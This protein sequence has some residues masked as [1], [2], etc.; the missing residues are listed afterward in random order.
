MSDKEIIN[1][2]E[3]KIH[4]F[5]G[6]QV[7]L[8]RDIASL[9]KVETRVI[10]QAVKR[11]S[12]R[13]PDE[14]CFQLSEIEFH[15]WRSRIVMSNGDK[16]GLRR[17]PYAFTEQGVAML[18]AVLKSDTAVKVSVDILNTIRELI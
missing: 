17:P 5:R 14:F 3:N 12:E 10:N 8:D 6:M 7:M 18:S 9:Y 1:S 4:T 15:D 2:I 11:N 13:F 16:M